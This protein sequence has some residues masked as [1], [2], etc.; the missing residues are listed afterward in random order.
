MKNDV[1]ENNNNFCNLVIDKQDV[2][3]PITF[4]NFTRETRPPT[5]ITES[6]RLIT[7]KIKSFKIKIIVEPVNQHNSSHLTGISLGLGLPLLVLII[8]I[9]MYLSR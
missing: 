4:D 1:Q 7:L 6:I 5:V 9:V 2:S 8:C 3:C